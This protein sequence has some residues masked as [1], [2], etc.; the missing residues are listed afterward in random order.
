M[1]SRL[2]WPAVDRK[3][4]GTNLFRTVFFM[5]NLIGGI[6]LGYIWKTLLDGVLALLDRPLLALD[7]TAD[8]GGLSS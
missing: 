4:R 7:A 2:P 1:C 8:S 3:L 6:V 5:P